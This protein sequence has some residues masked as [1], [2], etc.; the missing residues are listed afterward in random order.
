MMPPVM[1]HPWGH[2]LEGRT[3]VTVEQMF[4]EPILS[5]GHCA[6]RLAWLVSPLI[7]LMTLEVALLA[8]QFD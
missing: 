4:A 7:L 2:W 3:V 6:G 8:G 1:A 5:A